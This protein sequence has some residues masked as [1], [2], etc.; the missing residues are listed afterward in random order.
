M[1]MECILH[2]RVQSTPEMIAAL[3]KCNDTISKAVNKVDVKS[4]PNFYVKGE[5]SNSLYDHTHAH[6]DT[7]TSHEQQLIGMEKKLIDKA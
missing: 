7:M 1:A 5:D 3:I 6:I 2:L 4:R